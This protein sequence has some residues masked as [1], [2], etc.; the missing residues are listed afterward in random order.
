MEIKEG[1]IICENSIKNAILSN[2]EGILD[3]KF[4][5]LNEFIDNLTYI[6]KKEGIYLVSK[7]FGISIDDAYMYCNYI[8]YRSLFYDN[9]KLNYINSIFEYLKNNDL[10]SSNYN[11]IDNIKTKDITFVGYATTSDLLF[12]YNLLDE[13]NIE[14]T[15]CDYI[16][17]DYNKVHDVYKFYDIYDESRFVFN[18]IKELLDSGVSL[19]KIKIANYDDEYYFSFHIL[20]EFYHIPINYNAKSNI[21]ST[22]I[23]IDLLSMLDKS[24]DF[25]EI[26][27]YLKENYSYSPYLNKI[28][29]IINSYNLNKYRPSD[30]REVFK[31]ELKK[32]KYQT[33]IYEESIDLIDL[34]RYS[35]SGDEYIFF[36]GF[37]RGSVPK[38]YLDNDYLDDDILSSM[39]LDTSVKKNE[40]EKNIIID[41]LNK[42]HGNIYISYKLK[43]NFNKFEPS[44]II[45][46]YKYNVL[47]SSL[48][49]GINENDDILTYAK[50][51]DYYRKFKKRDIDIENNIFDISYQ[52]YNNK[53]KTISSNVLEDILPKT[54]SLSYSS[55]KTFYECQFKFYLNNILMINDSPQTLSLNLGNYAHYILERSYEVDFDFDKVELEVLK[56][57]FKEEIPSYKDMFFLSKMREIV[58]SIIDFNKE[59][60]KNISI[61]MVL[62]EERIYKD[63]ATDSF[64]TKEEYENKEFKYDLKSK[65]DDI[66]PGSLIFNGSID[67]LL[68]KNGKKI[69]AIIDYKT[70]KDE[71][72]LENVKYGFNLQM[73]SYLYLVKNYPKLIDYNVIGFYLQK[74]NFE[75]ADFKLQGYTNEDM[76]LI[77]ELEPEIDG[78]HIKGL[79]LKKDGSLKNTAKVFEEE[80]KD[81]LINELEEKLINAYR[82]IRRGQF[83]INPKKLN[84]VDKACSNCQYRNVCYKTFQD[85]EEIKAGEEDAVE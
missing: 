29:N 78:E 75:K 32:I 19:N 63:S 85:Y 69:M 51:L 73:P 46:E 12:A 4:L 58:K 28:I 37:N 6:P 81:E 24:N 50:Y 8:K 36:I 17:K 30:T 68:I 79:T 15:A 44:N 43:S 25:I 53:Y 33:D 22:K 49:N 2:L 57:V 10:F 7:E 35:V 31:Y 14:Y 5:T 55:L 66:K 62:R 40:I 27:K 39:H 83:I 71:I 74:F 45:N 65:Y 76:A 60:E 41:I 77:K 21:L 26:I 23:A 13:L 1:L 52:K 47:V 72:K 38:I 61:D 9:E 82:E 20:E 70:G 3:Y 11:F 56:K 80:F 16:N 59:Y 54:I 18:K 48:I 64:Y 67:K 42:I 34:R 84:Q